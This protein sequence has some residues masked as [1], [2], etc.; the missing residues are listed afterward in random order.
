MLKKFHVHYNLGQG[1]CVFVE[2]K[3]AESDDVT[4]HKM[5]N[6]GEGN[7]TFAT[8]DSAT[9]FYR[10]VV[11]LADG[12]LEE[13]HWRFSPQESSNVDMFDSWHSPQDGEDA[14]SAPAFRE[15]VFGVADDNILPKPS[16]PGS[17][18]I[19][20]KEPRVYKGQEIRVV[21]KQICNWNK[22]N[23]FKMVKCANSTWV[24]DL[25]S[26]PLLRE[27]EFKFCLWDTEN[28]KFVC[29][30]DGLNRVVRPLTGSTSV[31]S[32]NN[33][34]FSNLWRAA[35]VVAPIFALRTRTD[36]GSG[37]FLDLKPLADWCVA[38]HLKV[39][40]LLPINDTTAVKQWRDSYP[41]N[42]I[43]IN[44]FHPNYVSVD[45]AYAHYGKRMKAIDR[46]EGLFLN[47]STFLD[48]NRT[49]NWKDRTMRKLF[50][51]VKDS[52]AN[53][54]DFNAYFE[55]NASWIK[56]YA[57]FAVL[58]DEFSTPDFN[59]WD[60]EWRTHDRQKVD[61]LFKPE[62]PRFSEVLY[63]V[64]LQYHL[65]R[66]LSEAV[67]YVHSRGIALKGDLPIG[68][69]PHSA[70]AWTSP[71]LFD[72]SLQAGAPPDYFSHD[73]QNW[74]FPTYNWDVMRKD[75]FKWWG[76]RMERMQKFF[77]AFRI[78]H[79]LGFFRIWAIPHPFRSGLMGLFTPALPLSR[80]ELEEKGFHYNI[81]DFIIPII[82]EQFLRDQV[83][84]YADAALSLF[85]RLPDG[86]LKLR[87]ENFSSIVIDSWI[88]ENVDQIHRERV[89]RGLANVVHEVL[90]VTVNDNEYHPRILLEETSRFAQLPEHDKN[91]MR[92]IYNDF[93][94][95]R[96]ETFWKDSADEH[97]GALLSKCKM[98][99]CGEDLGMIPSTVPIVM[100][101]KQI[102]SL[103]LQRMPK[104]NW[105][106]FGNP[107]NYPYL[108]VCTTSSHDISGIRGWWEED[109]GDVEYYYYNVMRRTGA[110]P[111]VATGDI[112]TDI[113]CQH[114][115]SP[116]MLC[117][118][119]IQ[120]YAAMLDHVPHLYP[121]EERINVPSN[122]NQMWRYRMP[123]LLDEIRDTHPEFHKKVAGCVDASG[124][125][126]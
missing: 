64:F 7:N 114:L 117:I 12:L 17:L 115:N 15:A 42:A 46:E 113:V 108:S 27:F 5:E 36:K 97:L 20:V 60:E 103:E 61:D 23:A 87:K 123:F 100:Q 125:N 81:E 65:E 83:Y 120:D 1:D 37:E 88:E 50:A 34:N 96:H 90:F 126:V 40:Q 98:L 112:A 72:F 3:R 2:I 91:T 80:K 48:Y 82:T 67:E 73:G 105:E 79:I 43:S 99:V 70:D 122:P 74:G 57:A 119:P 31:F 32:F 93:F 13:R 121:G 45:T 110:V 109:R 101:R 111:A 22:A 124:R 75:G 59:Q 68:I 116:S 14:L 106:R 33:F 21:S 53:D 54:A 19:A 94:Y 47:D 8:E 69:N 52:L 25:G 58:R 4:K 56:D 118:N 85:D 95:S 92:Y 104:A 86:R 51:E 30:E 11:S 78:D 71:D 102:L 35:G 63:R 49:R 89:R 55:E 18:I 41:Y 39:I 107:R 66:Q 44:A 76:S 9:F 77:D 24:L 6:D 16:R 84:E 26:N 28:D 10:Y 29:Y 38:S 62:N